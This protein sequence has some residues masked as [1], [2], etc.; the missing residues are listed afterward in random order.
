MCILLIDGSLTGF[1]IDGL[2]KW[3][4]EDGLRGVV[5]REVGAERPWVL[6]WCYRAYNI[7]IIKLL[8]DCTENHLVEAT[9]GRL[10]VDDVAYSIS[11]YIGK[12]VQE[13]TYKSRLRPLSKRSSRARPS[14][15]SPKLINCMPICFSNFPNDFRTSTMLSMAGTTLQDLVQTASVKM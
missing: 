7:D 13:R 10:R 12:G 9:F 4:W 8:V 3:R 14:K 15:S 2:A 5:F 11:L 1:G 6:V